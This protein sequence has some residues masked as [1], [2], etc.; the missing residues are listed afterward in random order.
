VS[1]AASTPSK[2][3]ALGADQ[4]GA[5]AVLRALMEQVGWSPTRAARAAGTT[6]DRIHEW[7]RRY[8]VKR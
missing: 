3:R 6:D 2:L 5:A 7:L 4:F 8:E 1:R